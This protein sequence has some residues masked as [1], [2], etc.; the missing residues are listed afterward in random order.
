[1]LLCVFAF[2]A[3]LNSTAAIAG[4]EDQKEEKK[5]SPA[6]EPEAPPAP[7]EPE[8]PDLSLGEQPGPQFEEEPKA[9]APAAPR[10]A[11][12]KRGAPYEPDKNIDYSEILGRVE[13]EPLSKGVLP[14]ALGFRGYRPSMM[15]LGFGDR[16]PGIGAMVEYSWNRVGA[17]AYYSYL[18]LPDDDLRS[19][20]QGFGG[21][22]ALYRWLP[23]NISPYFLLGVEFASQTPDAFGGTAGIGVEARIF[24]GWTALFGYTYHSTAKRGFLGGAFG[25]SF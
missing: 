24:Y 25:W 15:A 10:K 9:A 2:E 18:N 19:E 23:F 1:M 7:N 12:R 21:L 5:P 11:R 17:G 8:A 4:D 6:P 3:K 13:V 20:G 22:Y 16:T 14:P